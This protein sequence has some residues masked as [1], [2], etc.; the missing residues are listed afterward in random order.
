MNTDGSLTTTR[1]PDVNGTEIPDVV[2][3]GKEGAPYTTAEAKNIWKLW[4]NRSTW[5]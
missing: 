4:L 5:K 1:V 2:I 3:E